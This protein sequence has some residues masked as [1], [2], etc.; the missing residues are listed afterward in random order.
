MGKRTGKSKVEGKVEITD[1]GVVNA[2]VN[3]AELTPHPMNYNQH[4]ETQMTDLRYSLRRFGQVRSI[5]VQAR[6]DGLGFLLVAGHGLAAAAK[7]EGYAMLRADV[8]PAEWDEVKVLAYLAADNELARRST[9]DEAQLAALVSR[10]AREADEELAALA[11][12]ADERMH[13]LLSISE[14][15]QAGIDFILEQYSI[16]IECE[17]EMVQAD[18]LGRFSAEGLKCRALIS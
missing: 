17:S 5:V 3:V 4:D 1:S 8:I 9:P 7:A 13:E 11:A 10:V 14:S 6:N 12:G 18:L 15:P 16:L 2:V